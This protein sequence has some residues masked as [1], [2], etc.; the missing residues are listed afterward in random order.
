MEWYRQLPS[1]YTECFLKFKRWRTLLNGDELCFVIEVIFISSV[2]IME[3]GGFVTEVG[4]M[5]FVTK[6][7]ELDFVTEIGWMVFITEACGLLAFVAEIDWMMEAGRLVFATEFDLTVFVTEGSSMAFVMKDGSTVFVTE[8]GNTVF[9][10]E[11]GSMVFDMEADEMHA[12]FLDVSPEES[13]EVIWL[14]SST[15]VG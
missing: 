14:C 3:V 7:G 4:W 1:P 13:V 15:F 2:L 12:V 9:V 8:D 11:E 6:A 5:V 10:M